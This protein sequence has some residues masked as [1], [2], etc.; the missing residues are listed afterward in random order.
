MPRF[1]SQV[2]AL[3]Q[4]VVFKSAIT[5]KKTNTQSCLHIDLFAPDRAES[6]R[7]ENE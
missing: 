3:Q 1:A 6:R 5:R 2:A 7:N 4:V